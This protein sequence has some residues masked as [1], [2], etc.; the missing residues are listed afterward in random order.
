MGNRS[1][2]E[3]ENEMAANGTS[4]LT[5]DQDIKKIQES[6]NREVKQMENEEI[7]IRQARMNKKMSLD[8]VSQETGLSV[9]LIRYYENNP[10]DLSFDDCLMLCELYG[11]KPGDI[12]LKREKE[13]FAVF[14]TSRRMVFISS[15]RNKV[16]DII[17]SV[18]SDGLYND[19]ALMEDLLELVEELHYEDEVLIQE[20]S[21]E[22]D[23]KNHL[24]LSLAGR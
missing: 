1:I 18:T 16:S 8:D 6:I 5:I 7:T 4:P 11:I 17:L 20:L 2:K 15:L 23:K 21:D 12:S 9:N 13:C 19:Q 22:M 14:P 10:G 24:N 3:I